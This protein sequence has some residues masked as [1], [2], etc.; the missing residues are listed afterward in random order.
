MKMFKSF[1]PTRVHFII[2]V[3][4]VVLLIPIPVFAN[5]NMDNVGTSVAHQQNIKVD[6]LAGEDRYNTA[7]EIARAGWQ[8]AHNAI[9]T[10]GNDPNLVDALTSAPLAKVKSA[11]ILYTGTDSLN[12]DT[13]TEIQRLG[14]KNVYI[15][16]GSGVIPEEAIAEI[17]KMG[18][19]VHRLG[20]ADRYETA[21]NV[22][23]E[24]M[25][26]ADFN[27][28][29]V[30]NG[31]ANVDALSIAP[32]AAAQGMPILLTDG[33]KVPQIVRDFIEESKISKTVV[34]GGTGVV[35]DAVKGELP[36]A[37]RLGGLT[38]YDTN[39]E[40]LTAFKD[41]VRPDA[42]YVAN[43]ENEHL[44]DSLAGASLAAARGA[45]IVFSTKD[46]IP[47]ETVD[48]VNHEQA[49]NNVILLGG[50]AILEYEV[51][52]P[53][54]PPV[55][56][57]TNSSETQTI[58]DNTVIT[59]SNI[60]IENVTF[61]KNLVIT[62]SG[63][64]LKNVT[65][66]GTTY[67]NP[68]SDTSNSGNY[69]ASLDGVKA[70]NIVVQKGDNSGVHIVNTQADKLTVASQTNVAVVTEGATN[71][72]TAVIASD[73]TIK[74]NGATL[75]T[76]TADA[77]KP[78]TVTLTGEFKND[79]VVNGTTTVKAD[80]GSIISNL[81]VADKAMSK[82]VV[83]L[84]GNFTTVTS[85]SKANIVLGEN[86]K[87]SDLKANDASNIIVPASASVEKLQTK[88]E[89]TKVSG[90]GNVNGTKTT[91]IPSA[92]PKLE[93][94]NNP[95]NSGHG[96]DTGVSANQAATNAAAAG[97]TGI[98]APAKDA[99][100]LTLPSVTGYSVAIKSSSNE[101]VIAK[102]GVITP[103]DTETT[104]SLV[105]TLT[106][107]GTGEK[108][109]TANINIV[110]PAKNML[111]SIGLANKSDEEIKGY[112]Y[113][114]NGTTTYVVANNPSSIMIPTGV[115]AVIFYSEAP[116]GDP[117]AMPTSGACITKTITDG[118]ISIGRKDS[119]SVLVSVSNSAVGKE[120]K[121]YAYDVNGTTTFVAAVAPTTI[122]I[123]ARAR[124]IT[125][126]TEVP[127]GD[128][129]VAPT[130]GYSVNKSFT[131]EGISIGVEDTW[132]VPV[133]VSNNSTTNSIKGYAYK[134]NQ[135]TTYVVGTA[136]Q[137]IWLP[138]EVTE[139]TFYTV[140]PS[141][142]PLEAPQGGFRMNKNLSNGAI[143]IAVSDVWTENTPP[144]LVPDIM[145]LYLNGNDPETIVF[146]LSEELDLAEGADVVG[147]TVGYGTIG[148]AK[149]TGK[150]TTNTIT[151][152][153][154]TGQ[155]NQYQQNIFYTQGVG[156]NVKDLA[157][158]E[159][160]NIGGKAQ[161]LP[162]SDL[163][164][165][166]SDA[167][168]AL[169]WT[170]P[171]EAIDVEVQVKQTDA[172][173]STYVKATY[174]TRDAEMLTATGTAVTGLT[175]GVDYTFRIVVTGGPNAGNSN[176][177]TASPI[178]AVNK[179]ALADGIAVANKAVTDNSTP[180]VGAKVASAVTALQQVLTK[181]QAVKD[182]P[183]ATQSEVGSALTNLTNAITS[184]NNA[185]SIQPANLS[186][187]NVS[188]TMGSTGSN[189]VPLTAGQTTQAVSNDPSI[190]TARV[191][192]SGNITI[193]PVGPGSTII[194]INVI[195]PNGDIEALQGIGV[196]VAVAP[197]T[198]TSVSP[199]AG[200]LVGGSIVTIIGTDLTGTTDVTFGGITAD[201]ITVVS[202]TEITAVAPSAVIAGTVDVEVKTA[203]GTATLPGG[204]T[205]ENA[206]LGIPVSSATITG[207]ASVGETLT[208]SPNEGATNVTYQWQESTDYGSEYSEILGA[209][210]STLVLGEG[211]QGKYIKVVISGENSSSMA[212]NP[213]AQVVGRFNN[214][215]DVAIDSMGNV[216]VTDY[217]G[218]K[219]LKQNALDKTWTNILNLSDSAFGLGLDSHDN[220][221]IVDALNKTIRKLNA[222][223]TWE[224]I[225]IN[226]S[227]INPRDVAVDSAGNIYLTT[228]SSPGV[229]MLSAG[230]TSWTDISYAGISM[231]SMV[232]VDNTGNVYVADTD[233]STI[234]KRD[235][236][237]SSWTTIAN[238]KDVT[239][240][241]GVTVD[242]SGNVY[243][244]DT[245]GKKIKRL[246]A[247]DSV[248]EDITNAN[249]FDRPLGISVDETGILYVA[250]F[251]L[252]KLIS[253]S[254]PTPASNIDKSALQTALYDANATITSV[255]VGME[256]GNVSQNVHDTYATAIAAAQAVCENSSAIQSD[257]DAQVTALSNA[258]TTFNS[259]KV[260]AP[261]G[262]KD[263]QSFAFATPSAIGIIDN[264]THTV[265]IT[266]PS[267]TDVTRLIPT[268]TVS[269]NA[270]ISPN[271]G[272]ETDFSR[273]VTYTVRAQDN[274]RQ[275]YTVTVIREGLSDLKD[276][277]DF[278][279][280]T[281]HAVI[282]K[283]AHT[284]TLTLPSGSNIGSMWPTLVVSPGAESIWPI[285]Y[286]NFNNPVYYTIQAANGSTVIYTVTTILDD[287]Q[288][289][290]G[291]TFDGITSKMEKQYGGHSIY[292]KVP[293]GTELNSL[294]PR[295]SIKSGSNI[296]SD[297]IAQDFTDGKSVSYVVSSE[298]GAITW[299]MYVSCEAAS[300]DTE[301]SFT[302]AG[303]SGGETRGTGR[304]DGALLAEI[305]MPEG[306][307]VTYLTLQ[308][309]LPEGATISPSLDTTHNFIKPVTYTVTAQDQT[310]T[311]IYIVNITL[312]VSN[313][314]T[315]I[316][317]KSSPALNTAVNLNITNAKTS[318]ELPSALSG[319]H[320]VTVFTTDSTQGDGGWLYADNRVTFTNGD[321]EIPLAGF[322]KATP[323][324][325]SISID[326]VY[327]LQ[328][329]NM[330]PN[331]SSV[332]SG[333]TITVSNATPEV[334]TAIN[335]SITNAK[336]GSFINLT[337][338][339][340]VT[341]TSSDKSQGV[342]GTV[343][344]SNGITFTKGSATIAGS[345]GFNDTNPQILT[346]SIDDV[347]QTITINV[348][349]KLPSPGAGLQNLG[350]INTVTLQELSGNS[351]NGFDLFT[352]GEYQSYYP[353][354]FNGTTYSGN[355]AYGYNPLSVDFGHMDTA[356]AKAIEN[357]WNLYD[358]LAYI[359]TSGSSVQLIDGFKY[360]NY[361]AEQDLEI[362]GDFPAGQLIL[363]GQ[364]QD[365][366]TG[367]LKDIVIK[368]NIKH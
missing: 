362:H 236:L 207:T 188:V 19:T 112:S 23:K 114:V 128:P 162:V 168:V 125:F 263:I 74:N 172:A 330:T 292:M 153:R 90:G 217:S 307:D 227:W 138:Q 110:V 197:P 177:V 1:K 333:A 286:Q 336:D 136:A 244:T 216:Y 222:G 24:L 91:D 45:E 48:Y 52:V 200:A 314:A 142:D 2:A 316:A 284:V 205:Y 70:K 100:A 204:Y 283:V 72:K 345:I 15:T 154:G 191:D 354:A 245:G 27:N 282:D 335:L 16:S 320:R 150:G 135:T 129:L 175:N 318:G 9:I 160:L 68:S 271:T 296:S 293:Y 181:A 237:T 270:T 291:V 246:T 117:L 61:A 151:L 342:S 25:K 261:A 116:S 234:L 232:A 10:S 176:T 290:F 79:V 165:T 158:N 319:Q 12:S 31:Y 107:D 350:L 278:Y 240:P 338:I 134:L 50:E 223:S 145:C 269:P 201:F 189:T 161:T 251:N 169:N 288:D 343:F 179:S 164:A 140:A 303:S 304:L 37:S 38:R 152:T 228:I 121:G 101:S 77:K 29:V 256:V 352:N 268:I 233:S 185:P 285:S 221:Y 313:S 368:I 28:V 109:D 76:V 356:Y 259:A 238:D 351:D 264:V 187:Q 340:K 267:E 212:S 173:D 99:T 124:T 225:P 196:T 301:T 332:S 208:A 218:N 144:Y 141:G 258:K 85:D 95:N 295:V 97:V 289:I 209:T 273:P 51:H 280:G 5:T 366:D 329:V 339:H 64:V 67:V 262:T 358:P 254:V 315:I 131:F 127:S 87:V 80:A 49:V 308:A 4:T 213:T 328:P 255:S 214:P 360:Y 155:W 359:G 298:S 186:E 33:D 8:S 108:A 229:Y 279:V 297:G 253:Y 184:F 7:I 346:V 199:N 194:T 102:T 96:A 347:I 65:V 98:T 364:I 294:T 120:I 32:I 53:L 317:S 63:V 249:V 156:T 113:E 312:P 3:L 122:V 326:G 83:K 104:V 322:T 220:L 361:G 163:A 230:G 26:S 111:V 126:Y 44:V 41:A 310:T 139:V 287:S 277:T 118:A 40:I 349:P 180:M 133:P 327:Q 274:S 243:A 276:I 226:I 39:R 147:F 311:Q 252:K 86:T 103:P 123:P 266:V 18:V 247:N 367:D 198:I 11:P 257:V 182:N 94:T 171:A 159:L 353:L 71:I 21:V 149:Y 192:E 66:N 43:G 14:V 305:N 84:E 105:L 148:S 92:P 334:F 325:L 210:Q 231:P 60:T 202:P 331:E 17:E 56:V 6:R 357:Y 34:V 57:A 193:T 115:S 30:A 203:G 55:S 178:N 119:W 75:G 59:G 89:E 78:I 265:T 344:S 239:Y 260:K 248:W 106:K 341:V 42:I 20:G 174:A 321:A 46:S 324:I 35:S 363:K 143:S 337:G 146:N 235:K 81:V 355:L 272:V 281:H 130:T 299:T 73:A 195:G 82:D 88:S 250:D 93:N 365:S 309:T 47:Q 170:A 224:E 206:P 36:N 54:E 22:A 306:T 183:I 132:D 300:N 219:V 242:N 13:K 69:N 166:A 211:Q 137:S 157:G 190:A 323:Q 58:A 302:I 167:G 275:N 241:N 215:Y 62:G 348:T